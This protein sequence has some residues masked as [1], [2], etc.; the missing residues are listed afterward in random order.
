[1]TH[2]L[3]KVV[4]RNDLVSINYRTTAFLES[5]FDILFALNKL[6]HPGEKRMVLFLKEKAEILPTNFEENLKKLFQNLRND[7]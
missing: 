4:M 7:Y 6:T 1:M 2:K 3:K 5:Y